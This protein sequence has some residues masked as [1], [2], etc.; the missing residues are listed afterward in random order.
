VG[1]GSASQR[2]FDRGRASNQSYG[3]SRGSGGFSGG[4]FSGG[5]GGRGGRR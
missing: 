5:G 2:D 1:G 4:G 3:S